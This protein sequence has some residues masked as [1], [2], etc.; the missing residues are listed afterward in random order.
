VHRSACSHKRAAPV[1]VPRWPVVRAATGGLLIRHVRRP[2]TIE[3][4][5]KRRAERDATALASEPHAGELAGDA[6]RA[7]AVVRGRRCPLIASPPLWVV[8]HSLTSHTSAWLDVWPRFAAM[9]VVACS[10]RCRRTSPVMLRL[11]HMRYRG[12]LLEDVGRLSGPCPPSFTRARS[13]S[14][15][16]HVFLFTDAER[17]ECCAEVCW[18]FAVGPGVYGQP[19]YVARR[20]SPFTHGRAAVPVPLSACWTRWRQPSVPPLGHLLRQGPAHSV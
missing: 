4:L 18:R 7:T 10:P 5:G 16:H 8:A 19:P 11:S 12:E 3:E 1:R 6:A 9:K 13:L 2:P 17:I 14:A 20:S 15:Y